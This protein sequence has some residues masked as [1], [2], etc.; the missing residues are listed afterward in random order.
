MELKYT[1]FF[2]PELCMASHYN[3]SAILKSFDLLKGKAE[4][5]EKPL[6]QRQNANKTH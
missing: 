3:V 1:L 5:S 6:Q 2:F 4:N